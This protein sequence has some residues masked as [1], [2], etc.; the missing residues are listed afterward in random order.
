MVDSKGYNILFFKVYRPMVMLRDNYQC[1]FCGLLSISNHVHHIDGDKESTDLSNM[2]TLCAA[3]HN[4][5][6]NG[7]LKFAPIQAG[8]R[9]ID[10]LKI[11]R[12]LE[13]GTIYF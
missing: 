12:L 13:K 3:H 7:K 9:N 8:T 11:K 10:L 5:A 2:V 6:N 4:S 1:K